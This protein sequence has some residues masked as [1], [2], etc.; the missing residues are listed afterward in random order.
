VI[1]QP[2]LFLGQHHN[3]ARLVVEAIEHGDHVLEA[4]PTRSPSARN[5]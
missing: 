2:G 3:P 5:G 1:E 4:S